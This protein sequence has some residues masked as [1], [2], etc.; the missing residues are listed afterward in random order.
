MTAPT[1]PIVLSCDAGEAET[2]E[3]RVRESK[4]TRLVDI[5]SIACGGH[6]GDKAS[7]QRSVRNARDAGRLV[8]A[9]PSYPDRANF[10]RADMT[11][12]LDDLVASLC[13]QLASLC[14]VSEDLGVSV[15]Q[16]KPHGA[17]YHR[18]A[19]DRS[20]AEA[21]LRA[22]DAIVPGAA[23]VM[24]SGASTLEFCRDAGS[25]VELEAFADRRYEANGTLRSRAHNDA[26]IADPSEAA[27]QALSI[28][29]ER[30][31]IATNGDRVAIQASQ[32]CIHS[33]SVNA[34]AIA[35]AVRAALYGGSTTDHD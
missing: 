24:P 10:G 9:H 21:V 30:Q 13:E 8:A 26:V 23:I 1:R 33:D 28:A 20:V 25:P 3:A 18:A 4:L 35:S 16:V 14:R 22:R 19:S 17:L 34:L 27:T 2:H 29:C 15:T 7:M 12:A 31:V 5:V 11:I 6:A 32:L